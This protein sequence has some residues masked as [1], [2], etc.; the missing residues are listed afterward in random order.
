QSGDVAA[1]GGRRSRSD[2]AP[3]TGRTWTVRFGAGN[4]REA[5]RTS[6]AL[7]H[8]RCGLAQEQ[9]THGGDS[10]RM[11]NH[12]ID[13][14]DM[15]MGFGWLAA[16]AC[17]LLAACR[18]GDQAPI[19]VENAWLRATPAGARVAAAYMDIYARDGDVLLGAAT[20]AAQRVEMH[21]TEEEDGIMRMRPL[22]TAPIAAGEI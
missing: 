22:Q 16:L 20:P 13:G 21:V 3:G 19:T 2:A 8:H 1:N 15:R 10:R 17:V 14:E 12:Q 6:G 11:R 18:P 7:A 4:D 5:F 9:Y